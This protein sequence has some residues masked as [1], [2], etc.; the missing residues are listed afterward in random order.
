MSRRKVRPG[1]PPC[2][3][4]VTASTAAEL[5]QLLEAV[6]ESIRANLPALKAIEARRA[7]ESRPKAKGGRR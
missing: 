2:E 5:L 1:D 4:K 3:V 7:A 6:T